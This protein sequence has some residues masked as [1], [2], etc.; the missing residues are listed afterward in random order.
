[1]RKNNIIEKNKIIKLKN[2]LGEFEAPIRIVIEESKRDFR[3]TVSLRLDGDE[4]VGRGESYYLDDAFA[5]LQR[6]LPEGVF[7]RCCI[8]CQ[9][10][11]LCPYGSEPDTVLCTF[12]EKIE[13]K[14]DLVDLISEDKFVLKETTFTCENFTPANNDT[15]TYSDFYYYLNKEN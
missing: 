6:K 15:Y 10:G 11:N 2:N 13:D 4:Y 14:M 5:D 9:Y 12:P 7:L 1:M 8:A 3:A